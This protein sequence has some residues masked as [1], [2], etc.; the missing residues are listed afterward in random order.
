VA[1]GEEVII[2]K[3]GVLVARLVA[4]ENRPRKCFLGIDRKRLKVP[5]DFDAPLPVGILSGFWGGEQPKM[6]KKQRRNKR[7]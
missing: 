2:A 6:N 4:V 1:A 7:K 3:A 5:R